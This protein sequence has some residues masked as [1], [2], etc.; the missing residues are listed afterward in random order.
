MLWAGFAYLMAN[1]NN[2]VLY[3]GAT[4]D[5]FDRIFEHK[6][7]VNP[8]FTSKYKTSKLVYYECFLEPEAAFERE[9]QIKSWSRARKIKLIESIN[10]GWDDLSSE[11]HYDRIERYPDP[12]LV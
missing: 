8:G 11:I 9:A 7:H 12:P 6:N 5:L 3:C 2:T 4:N 10:P 1:K